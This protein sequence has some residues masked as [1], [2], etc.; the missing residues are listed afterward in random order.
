MKKR[1][2]YTSIIIAILLIGFAIGF[3]IQGRLA[4]NRMVNMKESFSQKGFERGF[5]RVVDPTPEQMEVL[6]PILKKFAE[7]NKALMNEYRANQH[8]NM[9]ELRKEI[10]PYLTEDQIE[11]LDQ[12]R[13]KWKNRFENKKRSPHKNKKRPQ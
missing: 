9:K 1:L 8:D 12:M 10:D 6:R 5:N 13:D 7:D 11:R 2:T 3:L 4:H